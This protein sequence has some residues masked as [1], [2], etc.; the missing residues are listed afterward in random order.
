MKIPNCQRVGYLERNANQ[1]WRH[2]QQHNMPPVQKFNA[3]M[4]FLVFSWSSSNCSKHQVRRR[5]K[6]RRMPGTL[7]KDTCWDTLS[8][9]LDAGLPGTAV[10]R[11]SFLASGHV[12]AALMHWKILEDSKGSKGSK[13]S[14]MHLVKPNALRNARLAMRL[15]GITTCGEYE[16]VWIGWWLDHVGS[17]SIVDI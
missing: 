17:N 14:K 1:R 7:P 10:D 16:Y 9:G 4:P 6:C 8:S 11:N 13:G 12:D 5:S 2:A 3:A 15:L